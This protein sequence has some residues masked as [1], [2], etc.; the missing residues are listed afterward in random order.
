MLRRVVLGSLVA[1]LLIGCGQTDAPAPTPQQPLAT[2]DT[3]SLRGLL[4]T[5]ARFSTLATALDSARLSSL[6]RADTTLTV[7]APT[8]AAFEALP[9][10]TLAALLA[11]ARRPRLRTLLRYHLAPGP[12]SPQALRSRDSLATL[13]SLHVPLRTAGDTLQVGA[14]R[15]LGPPV[16]AR[17]GTV[18]VIDRV[19]APPAP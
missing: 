17:N 14:A 11:P 13:D 10:G 3:V 7:F 15:V 6:L 19:L 4:A 2:T 9:P 8:N 1:V 16:S 18:Y 12:Y 5:D